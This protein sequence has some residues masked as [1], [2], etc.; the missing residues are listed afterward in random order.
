MSTVNSV[1]LLLAING[2]RDD[3]ECEKLT[4][5]LGKLI[6]FPAQAFHISVLISIDGIML[7]AYLLL[8]RIYFYIVVGIS[9]SLYCFQTCLY[10]KIIHSIFSVKDQ[11]TEI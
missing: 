11:T 7:W 5:R 1:L 4:R 6:L 2:C 9:A 10:W 3:G 8:E